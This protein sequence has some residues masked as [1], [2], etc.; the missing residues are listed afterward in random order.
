MTQY[1]SARIYWFS[2][3]GNALTVARWM[4]ED[5]QAAG[6]PADLVAMEQTGPVSLPLTGSRTLIIFIF[7][8]HGFCA[9][10]LVL[11]YL[12]HF[13]KVA[14][15]EVFFANTRGAVRLPFFF[16]PGLSGLALWWPILLFWMRGYT[17]A[18]SLPLDMPHSWISF[19]PPN[20]SF[21]VERLVTRNRRI[22]DGTMACLMAGHSCHRWSVWLTLPLDLAI[23]PIVPV[24]LL[25]GRFGLAKTLYTSPDCNDCG[26]CLKSCPVQAIELRNGRP[27]WRYTCESCMRCMNICPKRS[28]QSWVTR[29][30][31]LTYLLIIGGM[32]LW[33][34]PADLWC[35]I[36]MPA[37][38][39]LYR[40]FHWVLAS[41]WINWFFTY[42]SFTRLW[43]RYMAPGVRAKDF[44]PKHVNFA[45]LKSK[46]DE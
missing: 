26:L 34:L 4:A 37:L 45:Q 15:A 42:T 14:G 19:F 18:G 10:W 16:T 27:F 6:C 11:R 3:T 5:C 13:S 31:L 41:Q 23:S 2:G 43:H 32:A 38:F 25:I 39:P 36:L 22:V 35:W 21:G 46:V 30:G 29:M 24:Y 9:P 44:P 17:I 20:P 1:T 33:P 28:I 8:T 7:P 40:I 12:W